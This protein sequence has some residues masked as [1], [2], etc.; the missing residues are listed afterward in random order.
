MKHLLILLTLIICLASC[1]SKQ[2]KQETTDAVASEIVEVKVHV[3][4]M[5]CGNCEASIEKGVGELEG[6]EVVKANHVDSITSVSYD[7]N[8]T[9]EEAIIKAIEKRGYKV[10]GN[11]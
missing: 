9:S 11:I 2:K 7:V 1:Q 10:K 5:H 4:G 6:I 8:K 3:E